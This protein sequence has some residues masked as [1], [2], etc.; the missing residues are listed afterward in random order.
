MEI[1][2]IY[3][4]A[5]ID[6]WHDGEWVTIVVHPNALTFSLPLE[7]L[8]DLFSEFA[9]AQASYQMQKIHEN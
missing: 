7:H 8:A 5:D 3:K 9:K 1:T 4:G 2:D 6:I